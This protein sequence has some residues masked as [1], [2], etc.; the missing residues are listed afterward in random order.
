MALFL[1]LQSSSAPGCLFS[2]LNLI[3]ALLL[4]RLV[5]VEMIML[6]QTEGGEAAAESR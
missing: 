3:L 2:H 5:T 6:S 4:N 1:F